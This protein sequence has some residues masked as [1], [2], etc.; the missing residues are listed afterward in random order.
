MH[1]AR[2]AAFPYLGHGIGLRVPHYERALRGGLEVDWVEVITENFFGGGG[3]PRA[4]LEAVRRERPLVFHGVSLGIGSIGGPDFDYLRRL[5]A[6]ADEF[7]PAWISDHVCWTRFEGRCS[8]ELLPLPATSAALDLAVENVLRAQDRLARPL[9]LENVSSYVTYHHADMSEW[10]FLAELARRSGCHLL[11]D[12]NNVLVSAHNHGFS[13]SQYLAGLPTDRVVQFHLANH[14]QY[15][16]YRFDDHRG[17][18]PAAVWELFEAALAR[19]GAVSSLVEWDEELPAWEVLVAERNEAA[20]RAAG[21]AELAAP[22]APRGEPAARR[23]ARES[24]AGECPPG[25]P[26]PTT[27]VSIERAQRLFFQALTWPSGVRSFA[28]A[29]GEETRRALESTFT[30]DP[31]LDAVAR[32]DIY[33]NAY[34]YRLLGALRELFPRLAYLAG[35]DAFHDFVTDYLLEFPSTSPDLRRLG[36]RVPELVRTHPLGR[37][38][39]LL[40]EVAEL[41]R[42]LAHALDAP[43]AAIAIEDGAALKREL[44][45]PSPA[46]RGQ[47]LTRAALL[48]LAPEAW[49][50]LLLALAPH[51]E[52]GRAQHD[53]EL[54]A[55]LC[56]LGRRECALALQSQGPP[57]SYLVG[58][59]AHRVYFRRVDGIE[60][61]AL[62]R[63]AG[64]TRF[65]AVCE[66]ASRHGAT[67]AQISELLMRWVDDGVLIAC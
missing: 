29:G 15:A 23:S 43:D 50:S 61:A 26:K 19:F 24:G 34:F 35:D 56:A 9:V 55:E 53:L 42:A 21:V 2:A 22:V 31:R 14:T 30:S 11:L 25:E 28:E 17:P 37:D 67:A 51:A 64:C 49:P 5:R 10:E 33:A 18:V 13:P 65:A 57:W 32:L 46:R 47:P 48:A 38:R 3:R 66:D 63:V 12:L 20:A 59:R 41:E 16:A 62:E 60:E 45:D 58:R 6:L 52:L 27:P 1:E 54:A 44:P 39:P 4:V 36:D 8:H 40:A 7:E